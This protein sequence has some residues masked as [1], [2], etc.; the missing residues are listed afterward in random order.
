MKIDFIKSIIALGISLLIAYGF[1]TF[2]SNQNKLLISIGS[3]SL[4]GITLIMFTGIKFEL[5]RTSRLIQLVSGIFFVVALVSNLVF[6]SINFI[7]QLYVIINGIML[8]LY[9]FIAY[10]ILKAN[11]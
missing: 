6:S 9:V 4:I 5:P 7:E 8:L 3:F 2:Q 1:Y 11:Q 10:S